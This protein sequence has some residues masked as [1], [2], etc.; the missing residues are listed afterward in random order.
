MHG[1]LGMVQLDKCQF[2][3]EVI[4]QDSD[5][6]QSVYIFLLVVLNFTLLDFFSYAFFLTLQKTKHGVKTAL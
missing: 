6:K 3:R 4:Q 2:A 5:A 1:R